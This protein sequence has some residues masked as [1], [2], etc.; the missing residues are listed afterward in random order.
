MAQRRGSRTPSFGG[1]TQ[2][3]YDKAEE[4]RDQHEE[5]LD[6]DFGVRAVAPRRHEQPNERRQTM[7]RKKFLS[8]VPAVLTPRLR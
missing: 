5:R 7:T 1:F 4:H 8:Y 2:A 6:A 3:L